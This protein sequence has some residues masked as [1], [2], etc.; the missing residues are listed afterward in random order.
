MEPFVI[1]AGPM[2][3]GAGAVEEEAAEAEDDEPDEGKGLIGGAE[4]EGD[5]GDESG[6]GTERVAEGVKGFSRL[7][8]VSVR[9]NGPS[10]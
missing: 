10:G 2:V 7:H 1:E 4:D 8:A 5:R 9:G 3:E 6:E